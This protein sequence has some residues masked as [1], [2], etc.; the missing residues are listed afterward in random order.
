L[1]R[2]KD[3]RI[4]IKR[5]VWTSRNMGPHQRTRSFLVELGRH[6]RQHQDASRADHLYC[7]ASQS[8]EAGYAAFEHSQ[9]QQA[10]ERRFCRRTGK[11][12]RKPT[13]T[14]EHCVWPSSN[15]EGFPHHHDDTR[16]GPGIWNLARDD[17]VSLPVEGP[18]YAGSLVQRRCSAAWPALPYSLSSSSPP[19]VSAPLVT[20]MNQSE[21]GPDG[22]WSLMGSDGV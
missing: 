1:H 13:I 10:I 16:P 15:T 14:T 2:Y 17:G 11:A 18:R 20:G 21:L 3:R 8:G 6:C 22:V 19:W 9:P 12:C 7:V 4:L 5:Q